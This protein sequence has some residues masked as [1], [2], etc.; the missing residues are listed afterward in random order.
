MQDLKG[1]VVLITGAAGAIGGALAAAFAAEGAKLVLTDLKPDALAAA[2]DRLGNVDA[3]ALPGDLTREPD[4]ANLAD[5]AFARF[6]QVDVLI[7]NAAV[8]VYAPIWETPIDLLDWMWDVN[9]KGIVHVLRQF[10][11]RM[12]ASGRE[13]HIVNIAS[14]AGMIGQ[15]SMAGYC[16]S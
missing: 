12:L 15:A 9:V 13:G 16:A 11:P 2:R 5:A 14:M 3:L 7:N 1:K 4:I 10:T 8:S 6:G